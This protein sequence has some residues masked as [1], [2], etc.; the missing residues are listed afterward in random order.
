M[1]AG[2]AAC[3]ITNRFAES[4]LDW[5]QNPDGLIVPG[6]LGVFGLADSADI[7][8]V[9]NKRNPDAHAWL[10]NMAKFVRKDKMFVAA[11]PI[12]QAFVPRYGFVIP[13]ALGLAA[14]SR[15][16]PHGVLDFGCGNGYLAFLLR[17]R[18]V[19]VLAIDKALP[20]SGENEYWDGFPGE[21]EWRA[22]FKLD[23]L[24]QNSDI[25]QT[26]T[27]FLRHQWTHIEQGSYEAIERSD[28]KRS[29]LLSWPPM[30]DMAV[31]ALRA[32]RG[33][34]LTYIGENGGCT[35]DDDFVEELKQWREIDLDN[36]VN[37][38]FSGIH[39]RLRVFVR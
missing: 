37:A 18:G 25:P 24:A 34:T 22:I 11:W 17:C 38:S 39:D 6:S 19:D 27:Q 7:S 12:R 1:C 3:M 35:A 16:S 28:P 31:T 30:D 13:T 8:V 5:G 4:F 26:S 10:L 2:E 23:F 15:Y 21:T 29:L 20:E 32:Y 9:A 33:S 14:I 36:R